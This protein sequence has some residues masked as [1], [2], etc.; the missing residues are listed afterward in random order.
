LDWY[1]ILA[2]PVQQPFDETPVSCTQHRMID[3][4]AAERAVVPDD[5]GR[6]PDD[7]SMGRESLC[8]QG[9]GDCLHGRPQ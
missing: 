2:K 8:R 9:M 4:R 5:R 1:S 3:G 7:S 6:R